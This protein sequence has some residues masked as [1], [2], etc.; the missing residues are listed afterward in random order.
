MLYRREELIS[1]SP[2]VD[3]KPKRPVFGVQ[4]HF[5]PSLCGLNRRKDQVPHTHEVIGGGREG[6]NP[7]DL[8][9]A[10]QSG[11][12]QHTHGFQPPEDFF[13]A[14]PLVLADQI[15]G[16]AGGPSVNRTSALAVRVLWHAA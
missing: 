9:H 16:M 1:G 7:S 5:S 15:P 11:L 10:P 6:E 3:M 8:V 2:A 13:Y 4:T 14:L 12:S